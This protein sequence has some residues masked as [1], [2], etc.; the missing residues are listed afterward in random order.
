MGRVRGLWE[1]G[2]LADIRGRGVK[3]SVYPSNALW[4]LRTLKVT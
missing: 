4:A 3:G 1:K 2:P